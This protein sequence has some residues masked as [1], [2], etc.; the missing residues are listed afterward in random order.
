MKRILPVS[1]F[2]ILLLAGLVFLFS[3]R[4]VQEEKSAVIDAATPA[5][6]AFS[7]V[8]EDA[9]VI[10]GAEELTGSLHTEEIDPNE[11]IAILQQVLY[12]YRQACGANPQ[13][14]LNEEIVERLLGFN[15]KKVRFLPDPFEY[16]NGSGELV[17]RW[18]S[19][20]FF[21]PISAEEME[22]VSAGPDKTLWTDDDVMMQ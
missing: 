3:S 6:P 14:G 4:K 5:E 2:A 1:F 7:R 16:L 15:E 13:G 8:P 12:L 20:Y 22:I 21:H 19:P 17:D 11:D 18:G 9:F 10:E